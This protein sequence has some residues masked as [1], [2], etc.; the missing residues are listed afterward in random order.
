ML[1]DNKDQYMLNICEDPNKYVVIGLKE[2]I[3]IQ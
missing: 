2:D 3:M 1:S